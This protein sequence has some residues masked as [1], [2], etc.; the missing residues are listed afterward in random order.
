[1]LSFAFGVDI[2]IEVFGRSSVQV[3]LWER[4]IHLLFL[5]LFF[6]NLRGLLD[7]LGGYHIL[8]VS[9]KEPHLLIWRLLF[10]LI[11]LASIFKL[12]TFGLLLHF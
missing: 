11:G 5:A 6:I 10:L 1:M 9:L 4:P 8:N 3:K 7:F 12:N 2:G